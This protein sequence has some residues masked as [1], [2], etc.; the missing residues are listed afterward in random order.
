[1]GDTYLVTSHSILVSVFRRNYLSIGIPDI[2]SSICTRY[3]RKRGPD[4]FHVTFQTII[5][6][7]QDF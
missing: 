1:M 2:L 6:L 3:G 7:S 5:S 4:V